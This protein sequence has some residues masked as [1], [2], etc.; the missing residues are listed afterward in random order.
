MWSGNISFEQMMSENSA[1]YFTKIRYITNEGY[2]I[3]AK[4]KSGQ[5]KE[6]EESK[7]SSAHVISC[8]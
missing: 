3:G 6:R 8:M 7:S 1:G 5:V 4:S 2:W